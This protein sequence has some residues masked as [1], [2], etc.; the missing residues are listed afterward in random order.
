MSNARTWQLCGSATAACGVFGWSNIHEVLTVRVGRR[1]YWSTAIVIDLFALPGRTTAV[2]SSPFRT[3][4]G[5]KKSIL[6]ELQERA[7]VDVKTSASQ[8]G[9][10]VI[11][12]KTN[13]GGGG[14]VQSKR[15]QS[16]ADE[17]SQPLCG[18]TRAKRIS[19][20]TQSS[21]LCGMKSD[22]VTSGRH[23]IEADGICGGV[24]SKRTTIFLRLSR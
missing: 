1:R 7:S 13:R 22:E 20:S 6:V 12:T 4:D 14:E 17:T 18:L 19:V 3:M 11:S 24:V 21:A 23:Q 9:T 16:A 5:V 10:V 2:A 15:T 8:G